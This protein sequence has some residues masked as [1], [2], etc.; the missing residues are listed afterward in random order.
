MVE[1]TFYGG[2]KEIGGNKFLVEADGSR[3]FL[4]FGAGFGFGSEFFTGWL[5]ARGRFGLRDYFALDLMPKIPGLYNQDSLEGTGFPHQEPAFDGIFISHIHSDHIAHLG[6]VD[7]RIPVYVGETARRMLESWAITSGGR[8]NKGEHDYHTFESGAK[9]P[10]GNLEVEPVNVDHSTP[11]TYGFI[12][13]T[14]KGAIVYTGDLRRHGPRAAMTQEFIERAREAKPIALICEGTRV[15]PKEKRQDFTEQEVF[16]KVHGLLQNHPDKMM[17]TTFYARDLDRVKTYH[18]LA[19]LHNRQFVVSTRTA[20]LLQS[21]QGLPG[22]DVPDPDHDPNMRIYQ[23]VME[24]YGNWEK[25]YFDHAV[26]AQWVHE[27]QREIILH[28]D[29]NYFT[30]LVDIQPSPGAIF[31]NS[32]SEPFDEMDPEDA[33]KNKWL[34]FFHIE[35]HQAHASGHSPMA[36]IFALV[37]EINPKIV[38][39]VHTE[40][41][42]LFAGKVTAR[43]REPGLRQTMTI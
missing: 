8:A 6:Y 22:F 16:D 20:H 40:Y 43:V 34:D 17:I 10:A 31:V 19:R 21:L 3:I 30:E 27:H 37:N 14:K 9:I 15:A 32:L 5:S 7:E 1:I 18:H 4:D 35:R 23:R 13:T 36:D 12:V 24:K 29:F 11:A 33:V 38:I 39:P 28:L 41:P 25:Q 26:N 2:V 42:E